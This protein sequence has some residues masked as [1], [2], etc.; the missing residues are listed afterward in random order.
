[1]VDQLGVGD[2]TVA[3]LGEISGMSGNLLAHHLDVLQTAEVIERR[4]S[5]GDH[6]RKYVSLRWDRLPPGLQASG[7]IVEDVVFVCTHNSAR[8]QF[9]A[10]LWERATGRRA[11]SAG[12]MPASRVN[13]KAVRVAGE[14]GIDLSS[15]EPRG[16][17]QLPGDPDLIVSVCDRARE[18]GVPAGRRLVHWSVP[19]PVERGTLGAFRNAFSEIAQRMDHLTGESR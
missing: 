18:A 7:P 12:N 5:E 2:R 17:D 1:M 19:D 3:E 10:A 4:V 15:A 14:F 6:R 8:S 16:Y 13:P 9:A 11:D